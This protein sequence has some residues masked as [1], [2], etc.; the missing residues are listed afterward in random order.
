MVVDRL[1]GAV[2]PENFNM[3]DLN[4]YK[5]DGTNQIDYDALVK[6]IWKENGYTGKLDTIALVM[7]FGKGRL[8]KKLVV[9]SF[10][11][12]KNEE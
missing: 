12:I 6:D 5:I 9:E 10:N 4:D 1:V 3:K 11:R 8:S 2:F 7:N